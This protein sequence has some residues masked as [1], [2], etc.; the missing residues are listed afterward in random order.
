M[1]NIKALLL[2]AGLGTRLS[3][4]TDEWP[5]CLMPIGERPLLEYWLQN[6]YLTGVSEVLVN[7]HHHSKKVQEFLNRPRFKNWVSSVGEVELL[8]TAG[9]LKAMWP[10]SP[11]PKQHKSIGA[12]LRR[13]E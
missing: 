12:S 11:T 1:K 5:K 2:S 3:P 6:L 9:S 10:F 8:G 4:L 13:F 7:L